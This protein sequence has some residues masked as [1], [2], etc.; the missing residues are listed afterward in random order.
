MRA[1]SVGGASTNVQSINGGAMS[2][3]NIQSNI[4]AYNHPEGDVTSQ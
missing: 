3:T 4:N 2:P 1:E